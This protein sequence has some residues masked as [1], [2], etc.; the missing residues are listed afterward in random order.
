M[1]FLAWDLWRTLFGSLLSDVEQRS[2]RF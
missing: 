1:I 2:R